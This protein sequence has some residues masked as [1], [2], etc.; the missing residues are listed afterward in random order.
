MYQAAVESLESNPI[1]GAGTGSTLN[2]NGDVEMDAFIMDGK[3][4]STGAVIGVNNVEHPIQLARMIM[5]R[6][7]HIAFQG[8]GASKLA[9]QFG[10]E[11]VPQDSLITEAARKEWKHYKEY[12]AAVG[13]LFADGRVHDTV[14]CVAL[15]ASGHFACGTSTGGITAKMQGRVGDSPLIGSG[16]YANE[17]GGVSTTGH[18][19]S[20]A[21][22]VLAHR[23]LSCVNERKDSAYTLQHA[24]EV[25]TVHSLTHTHTHT[26][27]RAR[28]RA[29][30][31]RTY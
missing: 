10:L 14:G 8:A 5:D 29:R 7:D 24:V 31:H 19:E 28:A 6:T 17:F 21:K 18:G 13:E 11:R 9:D 20:I 30:R 27:T 1:F 16:G 2:E 4:L 26:H 3:D 22:V 12:Q 25:R 23:I 15:D